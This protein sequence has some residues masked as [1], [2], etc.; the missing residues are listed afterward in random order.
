MY[1]GVQMYKELKDELSNLL[2]AHDA[3]EHERATER[4][5]DEL[6]RDNCSGQKFADKVNVL[7][8]DHS[9]Y[10]S[11]CLMLEKDSADSS[12]ERARQ[13]KL[14][15]R[16]DDATRQNGA[17]CST[18]LGSLQRAVEEINKAIAAAAFSRK[19]GNA[20]GGAPRLL[21]QGTVVQD[22]GAD[23]TLVGQL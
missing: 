21:R 14:C 16:R 10:T 18:D 1:D 5:C 3:D 13:G 12:S 17:C 19:G 4:K 20:Q 8:R 22:G 11:W 2:D 15:H 6:L 9:P 7:I 23:N